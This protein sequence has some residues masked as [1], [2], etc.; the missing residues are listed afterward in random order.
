MIGL[1]RGVGTRRAVVVAT[2]ATLSL[3]L[4]AHAS[5]AADSTATA[6]NVARQNCGPTVWFFYNAMAQVATATGATVSFS[7][8]QPKVGKQDMHSV[9]EFVVESADQNQAIE[10]VGKSRRPSTTTAN[11]TC[12]P[13][14]G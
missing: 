6:T 2:A 3:G 5:L 9:T 4:A 7:V 8:A 1:L 13:I 12:S 10:W 11:L 14:C